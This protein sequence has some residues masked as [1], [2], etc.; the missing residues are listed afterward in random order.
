[1]DFTQIGME[2]VLKM[3][4]WLE[5]T[6]KYQ[7]SLDDMNSE[8]DKSVGILNKLGDSVSMVG[9]ASVAAAGL[10]AAGLV[11]GLVKL[12]QA[13][14]DAG[15]MFD[16]AFD[17]IT[18]KT[19]ATGQEL[20]TLQN[21]LK[22][23]FTSV[24]TDAQSAAAAISTLNS[25]LEL[26]GPVL[27]GVTE[28]VL[29][30]SRMT[31]SSVDGNADAL[32]DVANKWNISG[33]QLVGVL[34]KVFVAAQESGGEVGSLMGQLGSYGA[35]LQEMG[36]DLTSSIALLANF[37]EAGV[38][39]GQAVMGMRT[40]AV[41]FTKA[42]VD[43][44]TGLAVVA[45]E[46]KSSTTDI[47][48]LTIA[49]KFFGAR[50]APEMITAIRNGAFDIAAMSTVLQ[51][52][53]GS[54]MN[55]AAATMDAA[56]KFTI[57]KNQATTALQPIGTELYNL[58]STLMGQLM[59]AVTW[60]ANWFT[61]TLAPSIMAAMPSITLFI[62][63][64]LQKIVNFLM[65][66]LPAA[67][68]WFQTYWP[69]IQ[70]G[71]VGLSVIIFAALLPALAAAITGFLSAAAAGL[72]MIGTFLIAIAPIALL[73]A[74]IG[75]LYLAWKNNWGG[76]RDTLT[77]VWES[78][79]NM[80]SALHDWLA[81]K[82][83]EGIAIVKGWFQDWQDLMIK[84][85]GFFGIDLEAIWARLVE[86][87]GVIVE[88]LQPVLDGLGKLWQG[89]KDVAEAAG[90]ATTN[91]WNAAKGFLASGQAGS[92]AAPGLYAFANAMFAA[93]QAK[94]AYESGGF[95]TAPGQ[96][97]GVFGVFAGGPVGPPVPI[98]ELPQLPPFDDLFGDMFGP[99]G[100]GGGGR[101]ATG[102]TQAFVDV[103]TEAE[104]AL[105]DFEKAVKSLITNA[106]N[107]YTDSVGEQ[108]RMQA[109]MDLAMGNIT[110]DTY[111]LREAYSYMLQDME[112]LNQL[113]DDGRISWEVYVGVM[114]D[115]TVTV[116]EMTEAL[117]DQ[118][119]WLEEWNLVTDESIE[120]L[121]KLKDAMS[122]TFTDD[123]EEFNAAQ[124][125]LS[126]SMAS[127][128]SQM[129]LISQQP[130]LTAFQ[131]AQLDE[132]QA[133][134]DGLQ[135]A[136]EENARVHEEATRRIIF[137]LIAQQAAIDG[138]SQGEGLMLTA[139]AEQWGL[140]DTAALG[141]TQAVMDALAY[142]AET[143]DLA[144][145]LAMIQALADAWGEVGN[146]IGQGREELDPYIPHS[147]PPLAKG[148]NAITKA[149]E[150]ANE[151]Y[152]SFYKS[153]SDGTLSA[154]FAA[155]MNA[156]SIAPSFSNAPGYVEG[157]R[158]VNVNMGGVAINNGMEVAAFEGAVQ[159]IVRKELGVK[160]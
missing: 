96:Q 5:G 112:T 106:I 95:T 116:E 153:L 53:Q 52:A 38:N 131:Q 111:D 2:A 105:I 142:Y 49:T 10:I 4:D 110:Q 34:D 43:I 155:S 63:E 22:D 73:I 60:F 15:V 55:T 7:D 118:A 72:T 84:I 101:G 138:V 139:L 128:Q 74:A 86:W 14:W 147:P 36:Y 58:A 91:A 59:P 115:G 56:E 51:T 123:T 119:Y 85:Y 92:D 148:L 158:T 143:G 64:G 62:T 83:P 50:A 70:A 18:I 124:Q 135:T 133:R 94:A 37:E 132:L 130:M 47:D 104:Q 42:G 100:G 23:V 1:M 61:T 78:F 99:G 160:A 102:Q 11:A 27:Q 121:Q 103:I 25:K 26:S 108:M 89:F 87:F 136:Y 90:V 3:A 151:M 137:D 98:P 109:Q 33:D 126:D 29:E 41:V 107:A 156:P 117:G 21:D 80:L 93:A 154:G 157:N 75:A 152:N 13:A 68:T 57:M 140:V 24:P 16:E 9:M 28:A 125:T 122:S 54:I 134:Y 71:M 149:L 66:T 81:V 6:K 39:A 141:A 8:T 19:G 127:V 46:I 32:S 144:G 31:K 77:G 35:I 65:V 30:M 40:A 67:I 79:L 129:A 114:A 20:A 69:L 113:L 76:M 88:W 45:Q 97:E 44:D 12:G 82:I 145:A 120:A 146:T 150:G 159:R 17:T 48:A